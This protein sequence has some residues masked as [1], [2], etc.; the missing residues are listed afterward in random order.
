MHAH[1]HTY[2]TVQLQLNTRVIPHAWYHTCFSV[3]R[4][5]VTHVPTNSHDMQN[6]CTVPTRA[7]FMHVQHTFQSCQHVSQD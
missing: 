5:I 6:T 2:G 1:I 7:S 3:E 4:E